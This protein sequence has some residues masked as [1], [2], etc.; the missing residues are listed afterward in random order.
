MS[1]EVSIIMISYNK[2]PQ[3]LFSLYALE[4]Q[5]FDHSKMEVI[6]VDD[7]STDEAPTIKNE[8]FNFP[9]KYIQCDKNVGRLKTKNIGI[10]ESKGDILIFIDSEMILDPEFVE[11]HYLYHQANEN[12]V[13]AG[14]LQHYCAYTVFYPEFNK[15]QRRRLLS[16]IKKRR[17]WV[18]RENRISF[19]KRILSGTTDK[20]PLFSKEEIKQARYKVYAYQ[21]PTFPEVIERYGVELKE[22]TMPWKFVITRNVSMRK[23]L[24]EAVGPFDEG[25]QGHGCEDWEFGYRLYQYGAKIIDNPNVCVY[26]QEHPRSPDN[27]IDNINNYLT[28]FTKHPNF[29]VGVMALAWIGKKSYIQINEII[30]E[31]YQ[32]TEEYPEMLTYMTKGFNT[33][34]HAVFVCL[35]EKRKVTNLLSASGIENDLEWKESML[36]ERERLISENKGSKLVETLDLLI[37]L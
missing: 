8:S 33:L 27:K 26:H 18:P 16:L 35:S 24:I 31:Y 12:S 23:S 20:F 37:N 34:F 30:T 22:Y 9:F 7:A 36:N 28:F 25:F 21:E 1:I 10:E 32:A 2:Y 4:N 5:T 17:K 3:N 15:W 14:C 19:R 6:L 29:D 13:V 11:Q